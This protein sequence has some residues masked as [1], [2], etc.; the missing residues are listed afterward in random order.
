MS[1][2]AYRQTRSVPTDYDSVYFELKENQSDR[3]TKIC[4]ANSK[5]RK[6]SALPNVDNTEWI[7]DDN[8]LDF[9]SLMSH[10]SKHEIDNYLHP[11]TVRDIT[12]K[13]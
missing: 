13:Q 12:N 11:I 9:T 6:L 3:N 1:K 5:T 2:S 7:A 10:P 8:A 4:E